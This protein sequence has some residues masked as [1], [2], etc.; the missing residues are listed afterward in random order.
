MKLPSRP[1]LKFRQGLFVH[2]IKLEADGNKTSRAKIGRRLSANR[3][4]RA[5]TG[6]LPFFLNNITALC[7]VTEQGLCHR[8]EFERFCALH[9][10]RLLGYI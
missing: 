5:K 8:A 7:Y 3:T 6:R 1:Q 2:S 4:S 9:P 10:R